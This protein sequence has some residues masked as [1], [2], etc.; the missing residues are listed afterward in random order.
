MR[1]LK[2]INK[3][4]KSGVV[5]KGSMSKNE[6]LDEAFE[7]LDEKLKVSDG[8]GAWVKDF[9]KSDAPQFKG[10][11]KEERQKMA[12]AAY[13]DAKGEQEEAVSPAQQAAIAIAK[14]KK[15]GK[16]RLR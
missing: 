3:I 2:L 11:S 7:A 4:K 16:P 8:A 12:V 10:K 13:L 9:Y 15:A 1:N 14:K 5:K 6:E